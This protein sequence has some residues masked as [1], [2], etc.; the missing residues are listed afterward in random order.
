MVRSISKNRL[1]RTLFTQLAPVY[2]DLEPQLNAQHGPAWRKR[3]IEFAKIDKPYRVL[4]ACAGTGLMSVQLANAYG[5]HCHVVATDFCPA[6]VVVA[7]QR[8]RTEHLH[9]RVEFKTENI[10]VM[11]FPDEFFDAVFISFGLRFV[12]DIRTVLKECL[13]VLK[14]NGALVVLE[15]NVPRSPILKWLAYLRREH[16]IPA[17]AKLKLKLPPHL[18]YPLHDALT[19]YPDADRLARM[20]VRAGYAEVQYQVLSGG[21]ATLHRGAKPRRSVAPLANLTLPFA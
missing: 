17:W 18:A 3:A 4:D 21:L 14:V 7:K 11:P 8:V 5:S 20:M 10:E 15:L 9:R 1:I 16:W 12:S 2:D 6:M 13:R 19:F